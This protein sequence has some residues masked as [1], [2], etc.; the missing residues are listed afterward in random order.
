MKKNS[1]VE[2]YK[3]E[4]KSVSLIV[5]GCKMKNRE[6]RNSNEYPGKTPLVFYEHWKS[7]DD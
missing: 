1:F 4:L 2:Q 7:Q 3:L 6:K 5:S